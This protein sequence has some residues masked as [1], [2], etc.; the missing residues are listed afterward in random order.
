VVVIVLSAGLSGL[1]LL[2]VNLGGVPPVVA[3]VYF[4]A[5]IP[6]LGGHQWPLTGFLPFIDGYGRG[7]VFF[8]RL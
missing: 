8:C 4:L 3:S 7:Y 6:P 2:F 1:V 5:S